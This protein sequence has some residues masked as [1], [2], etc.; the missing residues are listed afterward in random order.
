MFDYK[1]KLFS[2]QENGRL[3]EGEKYPLI[4]VAFLFLGPKFKLG[5]EDLNWERTKR[6]N[7]CL[8]H[9]FYYHHENRSRLNIFPLE[10]NQQ[11]MFLGEYIQ[12]AECY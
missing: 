8:F 2:P 7:G 3:K 4:K 10:Y 5:R 6:G 12:A 9:K 11:F 1:R